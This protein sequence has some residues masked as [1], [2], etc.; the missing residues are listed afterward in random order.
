MKLFKTG[1]VNLSRSLKVP[2]AF[3]ESMVCLG[4]RIYLSVVYRL[5]RVFCCF[6]R[7]FTLLFQVSE[8]RF[9]IGGRWDFRAM[10]VTPDGEMLVAGLTDGFS[11]GL[12]VYSITPGGEVS[13]LRDMPGTRFASDMIFHDGSIYVHSPLLDTPLVRFDPNFDTPRPIGEYPRDRKF[14]V[15][16]SARIH[17][18]GDRIWVVYE[19]SPG[20]VSC[21]DLE[22]K[23]ISYHQLDRESVGID[24]MTAVMD[25]ALSPDTGQLMLLTSNGVGR[26]LFLETL[27]ARG[28]VEGRMQVDRDV[29]RFCC[30]PG[31]SLYWSVS[32]F[33]VIYM[34]IYMSIYS[35]T[36]TTLEKGTL[37]V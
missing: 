13:H 6:E 11:G 4:E 27:D 32:R 16:R 17:S 2:R 5:G 1:Q 28:H 10:T 24:G 37:K 12:A 34:L 31:G 19:N 15:K 14:T 8:D 36:L 30:G 25:S 21:L 33:N 22:G 23:R 26:P 29:R 35:C 7:D 20:V 3:V 9:R 18:D